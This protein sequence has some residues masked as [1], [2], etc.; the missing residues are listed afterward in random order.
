MKQLGL[1]VDDYLHYIRGE[2]MEEW[3]EKAFDEHWVDDDFFKF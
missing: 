2:E 1:D 3:K